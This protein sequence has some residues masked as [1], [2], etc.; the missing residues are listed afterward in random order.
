M[1]TFLDYHHAQGA[2]KCKIFVLT[3]K[4]VVMT[5]F[6]TLPHGYINYGK[7]LCDSFTIQ[8]TTRKH[9]PN[10]IAILGMIHQ[11][12]KEMMCKYIAQFTKV[13]VE[14]GGNNNGLKCQ[15]F[16]KE[17]GEGYMLCQ[18]LIIKDVKSLR[19]TS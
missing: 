12:K 10:K 7:E 18:N 19:D 6:N 13:A 11:K 17:L 8:Y 15:M 2:I 1:D 14:V 4:R 16:K 3:L 9:Q 5:W